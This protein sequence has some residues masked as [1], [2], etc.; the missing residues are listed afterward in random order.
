MDYKKSKV[1]IYFSTALLLFAGLNQNATIILMDTEESRNNPLSLVSE[2]IDTAYINQENHSII[3]INGNNELILQATTEEWGGNGSVTNPYIIANYLITTQRIGGSRGPSGI[4]ILNT[5]LYVHIMN[6][7]IVGEA[8]KVFYFENVS[9]MQL[10]NSIAT[11][12][13]SAFYL[14]TSYNNTL[15]NNYAMNVSTGFE[16][17][18]SSNNLLL[19]NTV[20][21]HENNGFILRQSHNNTLYNNT[22]INGTTHG[23]YLTESVNNIIDS[24]IARDNQ[25]SGF[26]FTNSADNSILSNEAEN[27]QHGFYLF[28]SD[29]N[30]ISDNIAQYNIDAGYYLFASLNNSFVTNLVMENFH[31]FVIKVNS[32]LNYFFKNEVNANI[33]TGILVTGR[34]NTF[35]KNNISQNAFG[36]I[37]R[38]TKLTTI[39]NNTISNN[40]VGITIDNGVENN[41]AISNNIITN[42]N[43]AIAVHIKIINIF[44]NNVIATNNIG[45]LLSTGDELDI[46]IVRNNNFFNQNKHAFARESALFYSQLIY[47]LIVL[48]AIIGLVAALIVRQQLPRH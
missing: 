34:S 42:N 27:N 31:G 14:D 4:K 37:L 33:I 30:M 28:Q 19:S 36:F 41:N 10:S 22:V 3:K 16:L 13:L 25:F 8:E 39:S 38:D 17:I 20:R 45:L 46:D 7:T 12:G 44:T 15:L 47:G 24:N 29:F 9:N 2:K 5:D 21:N 6:V 40:G 23:F 26:R 43:V 35:F 11:G 18:I 1:L 32:N 48:T